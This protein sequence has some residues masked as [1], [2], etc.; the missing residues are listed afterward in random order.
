MS[1]YIT[2]EFVSEVS[3]LLKD[4]SHKD[5]EKEIIQHVFNSSIEE[6][7]LNGCKRLGGDPN[8]SPFLRKRIETE[9]KGKSSGYRL[10]FWLM[11]EEENVYL[12]FIHP[13]TGRRSGT[14]LTT[15]KQKELVKT[16][17]NHR[18]NNLFK[19]IEVQND[20]IVYSSNKKI[21]DLVF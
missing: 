10:Y 6:I 18:K 16:F 3:L 1:V 4:T 21:K 9:Y 7:K 14:N 17:I 12:L 15:L 5:C 20:R 11:I 8:K 13:K 19:K 2:E